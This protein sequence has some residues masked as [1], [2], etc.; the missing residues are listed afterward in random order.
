METSLKQ[1]DIIVVV[2]TESLLSSFLGRYGEVTAVSKAGY[3]C[4]VRFSVGMGG[5]GSLSHT[6]S[7]QDLI[8][9][10]HVDHRTLDITGNIVLDNPPDS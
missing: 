4:I 6:A 9:V 1:G 10:G 8:K 3:A 5:I 7:S 2:G